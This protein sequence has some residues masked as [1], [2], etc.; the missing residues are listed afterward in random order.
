[1][2]KDSP[3]VQRERIIKLASQLDPSLKIEFYQN[4]L[5]GSSRDIRFRVKDTTT[6]TIIASIKADHEWATTE[7]AD[8]SDAELGKMIVALVRRVG[9]SSDLQ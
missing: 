2:E 4:Q 1:M 3:H 8:R 5:T 7:V 9:L 6:G